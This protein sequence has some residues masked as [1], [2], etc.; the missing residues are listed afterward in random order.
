MKRHLLE[1][2]S[3]Q[4][5]GSSSEL[6]TF[7]FDEKQLSVTAI[8]KNQ[9]LWTNQHVHADVPQIPIDNQVTLI[10]LVKD[11]LFH[12]RHSGVRHFFIRELLDEGKLIVDNAPTE[13]Q[14][15]DI[16]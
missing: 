16:Q 8:S 2:C 6:F 12:K 14:L 9:R 15:A 13:Y 4:S 3:V 10:R 11:N 5:L 1:G 7:Q